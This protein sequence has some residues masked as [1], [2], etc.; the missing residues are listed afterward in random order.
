MNTNQEK[1]ERIAVLVTNLSLLALR[2]GEWVGGLPVPLPHATPMLF[3][4]KIFEQNFDQ[5][6][7]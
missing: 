1:A 7:Q 2:L 3:I 4:Q 6:V 5:Y